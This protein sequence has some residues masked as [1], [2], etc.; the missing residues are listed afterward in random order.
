VASVGVTAAGAIGP[1]QVTATAAG[2]GTAIFNLN[3]LSGTAQQLH[4]VAQP[5][6]ATAGATITPAVTVQLQDSGGNNVAHAGDPVTLSLVPSVALGGTVTVNTDANGLATFS[7]LAVGTVGTYF[8]TANSTGLVSTQSNAFQISG[9]A[10]AKV[11][12]VS[13]TPQS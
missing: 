7:N 2:I 5:T 13:G 11:Q 8:L 3:N 9:G 1:L 10:V 12:V 6:N 4:F